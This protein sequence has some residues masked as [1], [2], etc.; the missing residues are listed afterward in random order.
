MF[1]LFLCFLTVDLEQII[2]SFRESCYLY[3]F[4]IST[5]F[6]AKMKSIALSFIPSLVATES[7]IY[8]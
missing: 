4:T 3:V 6:L 2:F 1:I 7:L 8:F 5:I